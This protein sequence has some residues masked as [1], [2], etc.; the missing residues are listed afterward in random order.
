MKAANVWNYAW[1]IYSGVCVLD[2]FV[3]I[4]ASGMTSHWRMFFGFFSLLFFEFFL[5]RLLLRWSYCCLSTTPTTDLV[6]QITEPGDV[7]LWHTRNWH[8][9]VSN[10]NPFHDFHNLITHLTCTQFNGTKWRRI[11]GTEGYA[12]IMFFAST[13]IFVGHL[14][15]WTFFAALSMRFLKYLWFKIITV[16]SLNRTVVTSKHASASSWYIY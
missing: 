2:A 8:F 14:I 15:A 4:P 7:I 11:C 13:L 1:I 3:F 6:Y 9:F 12:I 5:L 10:C 16:A